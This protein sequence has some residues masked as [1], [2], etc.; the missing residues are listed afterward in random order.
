MHFSY[1]QY[2]LHVP[3]ISSF[4]RTQTAGKRKEHNDV[5]TFILNY[6][7]IRGRSVLFELFSRLYLANRQTDRQF[8]M[9]VVTFLVLRWL[10]FNNASWRMKAFNTCTFHYRQL[11]RTTVGSQA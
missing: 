1:L 4:L 10:E 6:L 8:N 2:V 5:T 11:L 7:L 9:A 3:P